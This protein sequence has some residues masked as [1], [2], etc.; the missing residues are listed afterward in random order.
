MRVHFGLGVATKVAYVQ[1]RWP[2]GL[3]ERFENLAVDAIHTLKE[4]SG[5]AV[6]GEA[7]KP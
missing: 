7:K 5:V 3:V 6:A 2:G 1:V 4:G